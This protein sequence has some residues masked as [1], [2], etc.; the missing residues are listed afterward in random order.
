M[1]FYPSVCLSLHLSICLTIF[2]YDSANFQWI[3][4][5]I[6]RHDKVPEPICLSVF[7]PFYL[8]IGL[9]FCLSI[10]LSFSLSFFTVSLI[11]RKLPID[12]VDDRALE[13]RSKYV[14]LF[15]YLSVSICLPFFL[16]IFLSVSL[17]PC[18]TWF[19]IYQRTSN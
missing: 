14:C 6:K 13:S 10:C 9:S 16:S 17:N 2:S 12:L 5:K 18:L 11:T 8:S 7:Q 4:L 19:F 15:V 1:L 3:L